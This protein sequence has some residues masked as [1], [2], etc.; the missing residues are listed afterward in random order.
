MRTI[1]HCIWKRVKADPVERK[2]VF[3]AANERSVGMEIPID[4]VLEIHG[5]VVDYMDDM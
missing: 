1:R 2:L 4:D 5:D 3:L